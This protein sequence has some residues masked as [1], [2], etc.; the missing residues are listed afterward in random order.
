[1]I[2]TYIQEHAT[3]WDELIQIDTES[4]KVKIYS[5]N[6]EFG[7]PFSEYYTTVSQM[8]YNSVNDIL[9]HMEPVKKEIET[10]RQIAKEIIGLLKL[11][12]HRVE[13]NSHIYLILKNGTK[14]ND[15]VER[16]KAYGMKEAEAVK[17][18]D[19]FINDSCSECH[20]DRVP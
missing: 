12:K 8:G 9:I 17:R 13:N 14:H 18:I 7:F 2:R 10:D 1:M 15:I 4:E 3:R 16:L 11:A 19:D 5:V 20:K 6:K